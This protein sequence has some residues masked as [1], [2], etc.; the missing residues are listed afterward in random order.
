MAE[1]D[2]MVAASNQDWN[3]QVQPPDTQNSMQDKANRVKRPVSVANNSIA[4][5]CDSSA[6][7]IPSGVEAERPDQGS[8]SAA[9]KADQAPAGR[10]SK[11]NGSIA[12]AEAGGKHIA[13]QGS[14]DK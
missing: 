8:R 3:P 1:L 13:G 6:F 10:A 7:D 14:L 4:Q 11:K 12:T 2:K 5:Q 9:V